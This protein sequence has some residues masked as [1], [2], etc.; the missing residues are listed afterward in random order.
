MNVL[1]LGCGTG[2]SGIY[3]AKKTKLKNI[4][5]TDYLKDIVEN[6]DVNIRKNGVD[7][8]ANACLLNWENPDVIRDLNDGSIECEKF[9]RIIASD[10]CYDVSSTLS[11][12]ITLSHWLRRDGFAYIVLP[13]RR[14]FEKEMY[15]FESAMQ[16]LPLK[17][18]STEIIDIR[19]GP[20]QAFSDE[21][22]SFKFYTYK[23][24]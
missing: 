15:A 14:L 2:L 1:E 8:K 6:V 17:L 3:C 7:K 12:T 19:N 18:L 10:I 22:E 13:V 24:F 9:D 23:K 5:I 11:A 16:K 20:A 4:Y 21:D